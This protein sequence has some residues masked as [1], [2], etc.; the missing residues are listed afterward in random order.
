MPDI[1]SRNLFHCL[2][3]QDQGVILPEERLPT[4][5]LFWSACSMSSRCS[6][7]TVLAPLLMASSQCGDLLSGIATL[8]SLSS[9]GRVP[10]YLG[11]SFPSRPGAGG[12][13]RAVARPNANIGLALGGII[14][15]GALYRSSLIVIRGR[16]FVEKL[17]RRRHAASCAIARARADRD[18]ERVRIGSSPDVRRSRAGLRSLRRGGLFAVYAAASRGAS[19]SCSRH[20]R[21]SVYYVAR[22][23]WLWAA[24]DFSKSA[25]R[26]VGLPNFSAR[27]LIQKPCA[28]RAGRD[29]LVAEN[30]GH[31]KAS[32]NDGRSSIRCSAVRFGDAS[33]MI[34]AA[35]A[36]RVTTYAENMA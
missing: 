4:A 16:P 5:R 27:C 15:A 17:M 14:A 34:S 13:R 9:R 23:R 22:T 32:P 28:D 36:H 19:R 33:H 3:R 25:P 12:D 35:A 21:L 24:I 10:S 20:R 7:P 1:A 11:S 26:L 6:V 29:R 30:L 18:P 8:S 2:D 31:I